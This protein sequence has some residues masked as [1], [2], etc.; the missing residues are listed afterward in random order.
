MTE[1]D[2]ATLSSDPRHGGVVAPPRNAASVPH[3][4]SLPPR[5]V[6]LRSLSPSRAR[7]FSSRKA[8]I[9]LLVL[10]LAGAC[11]P[12]RAYAPARPASPA[13]RPARLGVVASE[14]DGLF[15]IDASGARGRS[16][17][18]TPIAFARWLGPERLVALSADGRG[19]LVVEAR[20]GSSPTGLARL[21]ERI[22]VCASTEHVAG[23]LVV[24][25]D[26]RVHDDADLWVTPSRLCLEMRDRNANMMDYAVRFAVDLARGT[27]AHAIGYPP[28]YA[29]PAPIGCEDDTRPGERAPVRAPSP[30]P[31]AYDLEDGGHITGAP[32]V[33]SFAPELDVNVELRSPSGRWILVSGA[34]RGGD[35]VWRSLWLL[36]RERGEVFAIEDGTWWPVNASA[37]DSTRTHSVPG[38]ATVR[39]LEGRDVLW[40][41]DALVFP[42]RGRVVVGGRLAL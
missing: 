15:E 42:G 14:T 28:A 10:G 40:V 31:W 41:D 39:W 22:A 32:P 7:S 11:G 16:F 18:R 8:P 34:T 30:A 3:R 17:T 33:P 25:A 24:G 38:E 23:D 4:R 19:V 29:A 1:H 6:P 5:R 21:P 9:V 12:P 20:E 36:D 37:L 26:L 13:A 27:V 35:H 2:S